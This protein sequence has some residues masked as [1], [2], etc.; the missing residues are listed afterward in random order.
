MC[1]D[2]DFRFTHTCIENLS[3]TKDYQFRVVAE[4]LYGRSDPCEPTSIVHT[5]TV[6]EGR[7]KKG[8]GLEG[9]KESGKGGVCVCDRIGV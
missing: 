8:L 5:E 2:N 9:G 6:E 7:R 1:I 3:A 4:N